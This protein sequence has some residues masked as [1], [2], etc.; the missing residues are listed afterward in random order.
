ME[1][2][3]LFI[4]VVVGVV[5]LK[6]YV[7]KQMAIKEAVKRYKNW[8][9]GLL[10]E[11]ENDDQKLAVRFLVSQ[12]EEPYFVERQAPKLREGVKAA[13]SSELPHPSTDEFMAVVKRT[14]GTISSLD[15]ALK[16][17]NLDID[18]VTEIE[19]IQLTGFKVGETTYRD[20]FGANTNFVRIENGEL[21]TDTFQSTWLLLTNEQVVICTAIVN[22]VTGEAKLN[23]QEFFYCDI[24]S[25]SDLE[26][27]T[28]YRA[29]NGKK[30]VGTQMFRIV[31]SGDKFELAAALTEDF[32]SKVKAL[33]SKL[34]EKKSA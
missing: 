1:G 8:L 4:V 34:R 32:D 15:A 5:C 20:A 31:V 13:L 22:A 16:K 25:M 9:D 3:I 29:H 18:E 26:E 28:T 7:Q 17:A 23:D 14:A 2:F 33:K 10:K 24:T 12:I 27:S 21:Y 11:R 6:N 30:T 19:P